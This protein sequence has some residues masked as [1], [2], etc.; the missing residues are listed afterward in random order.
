MKNRY[1]FGCFICNWVEKV[2]FFSWQ[3]VF[4]IAF[5]FNAA[6]AGS[7]AVRFATEKKPNTRI[8]GLVMTVNISSVIWSTGMAFMSLQTDDNWAYIFRIIG[9]LGT[10][11]FMIAVQKTMCIIS[12]I[13]EKI[14]H[15]LNAIS[16]SGILIYFAYIT[17]GQ[18]IFVHNSIG[19]TFYFRS[20]IINVVYSM[21]F[22]IVSFDIFAVTI[23]TLTHHKLQRVR[24][25][26]V[27]F[28]VV[29][30]FVFTGA[31][32]DMIV[33]SLGHPALP[34]SAITH[35]WGVVV[36]W[37]A[38]HDIYK[39]KITI[40]NMSEYIYFS[41]G[42][43]V[44]VLDS[45]K[46][47]KIMNDASLA[48]FG[49][50]SE[51]VENR[52]Y[53]LSELFNVDNRALEFEG[54]SILVETKDKAGIHYE[55]AVSKID[56]K[57]GDNVGYILIAN[58]L[59]DHYMVINKLEEAKKAADAANMSK[60]L[61]LA[62][63]SHEIRTPMNAVLGISQIAIEED[64]G[65]TAKGYFEDIIQAGNTLLATINAILNISKIELGRQELICSDYS[66][67]KLLKEVSLIIGT[68]ANKKGLDFSMSV[69]PA[70]PAVLHGDIDKIREI[71][72]NI[73]NNSVKYSNEGSITL[74]VKVLENQD[75]KANI[76]FRMADTG[77][78]IKKE[79]IN[80]IFEVFTRTDIKAN[81][82]TEGTGL[83][84]SITKGLVELMKGTIQVDSEYGKGTCFTVVI[85]QKVIRT[86]SDNAEN[87]TD[88]A[89]VP[90]E[91]ISYEKLRA[92]G[93][94]DNAINRTILS[95][96]LSKFGLQ[97][98]MTDSGAGSIELCSANHYDV[99]FMDLMM[100]EMDGLEAMN[101]IRKIPYYNGNSSV[102]IVALTANMVEGVKEE[103][104]S[105][106]FDA[107]IGKPYKFEELEAIL[108]SAIK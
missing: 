86:E 51:D 35:F 24:K 4:L 88:S 52:G 105:E 15:I 8:N 36:F 56:D 77:I 66:P 78:G 20:G 64:I 18:T 90:K 40:A 1:Y 96:C 33:P 91:Q 44:M 108:N 104:L 72:I 21:Y 38:I 34:G 7:Y 70:M 17:P 6:L 87:S 13:P 93:V 97:F 22:V 11:V 54:R 69:D 61:F 98:D 84:L 39:T 55:L 63:M 23:Y 101:E 42:I 26:A 5:S 37:Y 92:L 46:K 106:G 25:S 49:V 9:I 19:T 50:A 102:K 16:Y 48:S 100:P 47:I 58:D 28:V 41:L 2:M 83:G 89:S 53:E 45:D 81:R 99:I 82:K 68:Q 43:P 62:N 67:E 59:S 85:E 94:D 32:G 80:S 71:L 76:Q 60:S 30:L 3:I 27:R 107:F 31:I 10:F 103:M 79:D 57:Y 73:L 75:G 65:D 74:E 14:Q 95:K 12:E 29:E